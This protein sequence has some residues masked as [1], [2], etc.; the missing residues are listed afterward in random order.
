[1]AQQP[2]DHFIGLTKKYKMPF[3]TTFTV[4]KHD[5]DRNNMEEVFKSKYYYIIKNE[6]SGLQRFGEMLKEIPKQFGT[7]KSPAFAYDILEI[8][9]LDIPLDV[10]KMPIENTCFLDAKEDKDL[11]SRITKNCK[12]L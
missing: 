10:D 7:L 3:I 5:G 4:L 1:M 2:I 9:V 11:L 8:S 12:K 6:R